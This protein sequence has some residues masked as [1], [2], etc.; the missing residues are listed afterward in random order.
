[1]RPRKYRM[2]CGPRLKFVAGL[3]DG[4]NMAA[5]CRRFGVSRTTGCK[6]LQRHN[7]CGLAG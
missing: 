7:S 5:L 4:E 3:L 6:I 2:R 1:L